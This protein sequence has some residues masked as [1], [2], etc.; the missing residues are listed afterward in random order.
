MSWESGKSKSHFEL[1]ALLSKVVTRFPRVSRSRLRVTLEFPFQRSSKAT[2]PS[3]NT[4]LPSPLPQQQPGAGRGI[5]CWRS[6]SAHSSRLTP[7][8]GPRSS[9]VVVGGAVSGVR[10]SLR[11]GRW[12]WERRALA[13]GEEAE[14]PDSSSDPQT[15]LPSRDRTLR[16]PCPA[17]YTMPTCP[18]WWLLL[19]LS[20]WEPLLRSAEVRTRGAK[21]LKA[22]RDVGAG[23]KSYPTGKIVSRL[24]TSPDSNFDGCF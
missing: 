21:D 7:L 17:A 9:L 13:L 11:G 8:P 1:H 12:R 19:L 20:L 2:A 14:A 5:R 15:R 4:P 24:P 16:S 18:P 6:V 10:D 22:W 23:F 3:A